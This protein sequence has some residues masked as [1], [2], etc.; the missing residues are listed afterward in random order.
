MALEILAGPFNPLP[1]PGPYD[2][3]P[4]TGFGSLAGTSGSWVQGLGLLIGGVAGPGGSEAGMY[5]LELD[6]TAHWR[7]SYAY[8]GVMIVNQPGGALGL[9]VMPDGT[10][11]FAFDPL[12]GQ[13]PLAPLYT[14]SAGF[15][16]VHV[17]CA[18]RFVQFSGTEVL[19]SPLTDGHTF[20]PEY[21]W[22]NGFAINAPVVSRVSD[23]VVCVCDTTAGGVL[24][25]DTAKH[26]Q[27]GG[28]RYIENCLGAWYVPKHDIFVELNN[29]AQLVIRADAVRPVFLSNPIVATPPLPLSDSVM[30]GYASVVSVV[31]TGDR[32]EP[33]VGELVSWNIT[34]GAGLLSATQS[35][36][37]ATGTAQIQLIE[38][39]GASGTV[40][41]QAQLS[42]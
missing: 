18:N 41:V 8:S 9:A 1:P 22:P 5:A 14:C 31:A 23:T 11:I 19:S 12:V 42:C 36:T 34:A 3:V 15:G 30:A 20:T 32:N 13:P 17:I 4:G 35:T 26:V 39:V 27:V 25:Y 2:V 33:C 16:A 7:S 29:G 38:P 6:G 40:T 37:D 21:T 28:P 10:H 24:F